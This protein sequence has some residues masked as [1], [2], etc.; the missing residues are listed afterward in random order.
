M[1][2]VSISGQNFRRRGES[3][4]YCKGFSSHNHLIFFPS[5]NI[6]RAKKIWVFVYPVF[7]CTVSKVALLSGTARSMEKN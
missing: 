2:S 7:R 6:N 1:G 4:Y 3:V 5:K